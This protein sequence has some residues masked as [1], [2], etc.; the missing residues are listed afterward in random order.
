MV[1]ARGGQTLG[2]GVLIIMHG[3][4]NM[5]ID[6]RWG[7]R[8]VVYLAVC[9]FCGVS[10]GC[11]M[12]PCVGLV[13]SLFWVLDVLCGSWMFFCVCF[14]RFCVVLGCL[15]WHL[16]DRRCGG[17]VWYA[18]LR[19]VGDTFSG[20]FLDAFSSWRRTDAVVGVLRYT[21]LTGDGGPPRRLCPGISCWEREGSVLTSSA[22][23]RTMAV[24]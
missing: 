10:G 6:R 20:S 19:G 2:G 1:L 16:E 4:S 8:L 13:C 9:G 15:F 3:R 17:G 12:G 24:F 21:S 23:P 18:S 22:Q 14:I 11:G 5:T 7:G